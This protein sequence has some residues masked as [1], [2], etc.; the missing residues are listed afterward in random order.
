[1]KWRRGRVPPPPPW[2]AVPALGPFLW[3]AGAAVEEI[4]A[5]SSGQAHL[6]QAR[7]APKTFSSSLCDSVLLGR[8][9]GVWSALRMHLCLLQEGTSS[10]NLAALREE[11]RLGCVLQR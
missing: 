3:R 6:S 5:P 8:H 1:M 11:G 9:S 7:A 10:Q 4:L 2:G